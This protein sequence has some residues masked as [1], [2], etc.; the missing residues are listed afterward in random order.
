MPEVKRNSILNKSSIIS[1][2]NSLRPDGHRIDFIAMWLI[3][4]TDTGGVEIK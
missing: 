3:S 1:L 2:N 4:E